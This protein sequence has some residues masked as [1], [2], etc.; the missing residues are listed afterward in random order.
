MPSHQEIA[1]P[2]VVIGGGGAGAIDMR[3]RAQADAAR[4]QREFDAQRAQRALVQEELGAEEH[5]PGLPVASA[6]PSAGS[7]HWGGRGGGRG[8]ARSSSDFP[9]LGSGAP[10]AAGDGWGAGMGGPG[11]SKGQ[12]KKM[13]AKSKRN[14]EQVGFGDESGLPPAHIM[15]MGAPAALA[16]RNGG[17][18]NGAAPAVAAAPAVNAAPATLAEDWTGERLSSARAAPQRRAAPIQTAASRFAALCVEA[19]A[20]G[21]ANEL[22]AEPQSSGRGACAPDSAAAF[23]ALSAAAPPGLGGAGFAAARS[24]ARQPAATSRAP[25]AAAAAAAGADFPTLGVG[26]AAALPAQWG[27]TIGAAPQ[28]AAAPPARQPEVASRADF[29]TLGG[30]T[31]GGRGGAR[32][33]AAAYGQVSAGLK[34]ANEAVL[35]SIQVR[36]TFSTPSLACAFLSLSEQQQHVGSAGHA[37]TVVP[38][39]AVALPDEE[40]GVAGGQA[41]DGGL[42][43][44][45]ALPRPRRPHLCPHG[46]LPRHG[47]AR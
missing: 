35:A 33:V 5:F 17:D 2:P 4:E 12:K 44:A 45:A 16:S 34:D 30:G 24:A 26:A 37:G 15:E 28:P 1:R 13:K 22:A 19:A 10:A 36:H 20:A 7:T 32:A 14:A 9:A 8:G 6:G 31:G 3:A 38:S 23:P 25:A 47:Q 27:A 21:A 39:R 40:Q 41:G 18:S 29:P 43:R 42:P 46:H 11:L